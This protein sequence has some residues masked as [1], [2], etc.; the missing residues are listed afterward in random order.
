MGSM[1]SSI[2]RLSRHVRAGNVPFRHSHAARGTLVTLT[3]LLCV[4]LTSAALAQIEVTGQG[5]ASAPPAEAQLAIRVSGAGPLA[6]DANVKFQDA[7]T[8][9]LEA[10]K[11]ADIADLTIAEKGTVVSVASNQQ[12]M[13]QM[14]QGMVDESAALQMDVKID[15][16]LECSMVN[17]DKVESGVVAERIV[18]LIDTARTA[19]LQIGS[20]PPT[21]Y[22][23]LQMRAMQGGE[24]GGMVR[25]KPRDP[26]EL[27]RQA[28]AK[29][30][31]DARTKAEELA[32]AANVKLGRIQAVVVVADGQNGSWTPWGMRTGGEQ[33][34]VVSGTLTDI[35]MTV[36]VHV[37]FAV[38]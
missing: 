2:A 30:I 27:R 11:A 29:A 9:A 17:L 36:D 8:Q 20:S 21:N 23:E 13:M 34:E 37:T 7:K 6:A 25:F 26:D 3:A 1:K 33:S 4:G 12:Q 32:K 15:E 22:Y 35:T 31:G 28:Y 16:V 38:E 14:M 5:S 24:E 19:N 10:L 18:K